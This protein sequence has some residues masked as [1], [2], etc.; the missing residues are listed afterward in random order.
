MNEIEKL[1]KITKDYYAQLENVYAQLEKMK[2]KLPSKENWW[3]NNFPYS[4]YK[5][6]VECVQRMIVSVED[7]AMTAHRQAHEF[8]RKEAKICEN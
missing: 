6:N 3:E 5:S 8:A 4:I 2:N 1:D 7:T